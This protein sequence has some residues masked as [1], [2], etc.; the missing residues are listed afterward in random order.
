MSGESDSEGS[1]STSANSSTTSDNCD[2]TTRDNSR[3]TVL[4]KLILAHEGWFNVF[5]D[6]EYAN[7]TFPAFAEFHS[8]G[9]KYV[10]TKR[11]KLW[12]VDAHEYLFF[13]TT[14]TLSA[15]DV[16]EWIDFMTTQALKKVDPVPDHMSSYISLVIVADSVTDDA[17]K[18]I[19]KARFHKEFSFGLR[20]WA[21]LR[22]AAVDLSSQ[23]VLTNAA[24]KEMR[25]AL[26]ANAGIKSS[27]KGLFRRR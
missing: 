24:G 16:A 23:C 6:Y 21:D 27:K 17:K 22:L 7:R 14:E 3:A 2:S 12:E 25:A 18:A 9:E 20:G 4:K 8:H 26:E 19:R 15:T 1:Q 5:P 11:A 13:Q 10:L